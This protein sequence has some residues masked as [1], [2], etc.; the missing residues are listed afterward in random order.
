MI[1]YRNYADKMI[2]VDRLETKLVIIT[3][4]I[5]SRV[6]LECTIFGDK[7]DGNIHKKDVEI[8]HNIILLSKVC[9][10]RESTS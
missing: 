10:R 1:G 2:N 7:I 4:S 9:V 8:K 3:K 6:E 5:L